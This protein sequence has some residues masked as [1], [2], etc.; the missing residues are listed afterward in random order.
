MVNDNIYEWVPFFKELSG[1]LGDYKERQKELVELLN[2]ARKECGLKE[3]WDKDGTEQVIP[4]D[5]IDPF[6]FFSLIMTTGVDKR[7]TQL[8]V[9]AKKLGMQSHVPKSF[10]GVPKVNPQRAMLF[11]FLNDRDNKDIPLLW[12]FYESAKLDRLSSKQWDSILEL[13]GVALPRL[14]EM[15]FCCFPEKFL[16][17]NSPIVKYLSSIDEFTDEIKKIKKEKSFEAYLMLLEHCKAYFDKPFAQISDLAGK[18][19]SGSPNNADKQRNIEKE[20]G[21]LGEG[22]RKNTGKPVLNQ[23]L[24]GPPGTGK[25]Y[26]TVRKAVEIC[27]GKVYSDYNAA[28]ARYK[29]LKEKGRIEFVTF[30]QSY[31]YE[32]FIEGIRADTD[33]GEISYKKEDG[34][35]KRLAINAQFD[36]SVKEGA[37]S[38]SLGFHERYGKLVAAFNDDEE[39]ILDSKTDKPIAVKTISKRGNLH[40]YHEG[41]DKRYTVSKDRLKKL[42]DQFDTLDKLNKVTNL[43]KEFSDVI[44]GANQTTYWSALSYMLK[45]QGANSVQENSF[46]GKLDYNSKKAWLKE[47]GSCALV[48]QPNNYVLII[49]EINRGNLSKI[50]GELITLIEEDKRLGAEHEMTV[51]LPVSGDEFGVPSNLHIIGTMNTADRSIAMMDTALRRRFAFEEMM[52]DA[53]V[54]DD[55]GNNGIINVQLKDDASFELNL[56]DMLNKINQRIEVLYDREH[57]I[58][59]AYFMPLKEN[60]TI[61]KLSSIFKNKV[62]PLLAEYF[63]EDWEKIRMVLGDNKKENSKHQ[64]VIEKESVKYND[65][66]GPKV[67]LGSDDERKVYERNPEA[68]KHAE[69]Y[70]GIYSEVS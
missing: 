31:G 25:T 47:Q 69:S 45:L 66:F 18:F 52:P 49:D 6:T 40:C 3:V 11:R 60:P 61:D 2:V 29:D 39:L 59:H 9:I 64:F 21:S 55:F 19:T 32:E 46:E 36:A 42:Y 51:R 15:L 57:T 41:S 10:N 56:K 44:G 68:L 14:T 26:N 20:Q 34:V 7:S 28:K 27:D 53:E 1:K 4:L 24:Y 13:W 33:E 23:I 22:N 16:P 67:D 65:L 62:I 50:F 58:G 54:F 17:F 30:H 37:Q 63:F 5:E 38:K 35:F 12:D 8:E 48:K 43:N 70:F